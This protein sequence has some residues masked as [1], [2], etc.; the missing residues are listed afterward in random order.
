[1]TGAAIDGFGA[2]HILAIGVDRYPG[3]QGSFA[4]L[5]L[6]ARTPE[7]SRPPRRPR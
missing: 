5:N 4:D 1:M 3:L 2:L 7:R 6:P